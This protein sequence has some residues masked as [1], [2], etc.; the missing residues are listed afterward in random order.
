MSFNMPDGSHFY[1]DDVNI[2]NSWY[3]VEQ[4]MNNKMYF[5]Y[6]V[7]M[8]E[9]VGH[10]DIIVDVPSEIFNSESFQIMLQ[11]VLNAATGDAVF[12]ATYDPNRNRFNITSLYATS[13]LL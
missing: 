11:N 10:R 8:E 5:R 7:V 1:M 2:P 9:D 12:T 4:S 6:P 3:S 13:C